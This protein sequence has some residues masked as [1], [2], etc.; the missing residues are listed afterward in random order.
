[1]TDLKVR[2]TTITERS[3]TEATVEIWISDDEDSTKATEEISISV[4]V[5][6]EK[7]PLLA[8]VQGAA[9]E[10]AQTVLKREIQVK[11]LLA[12]S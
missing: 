6:Y 10:C 7:N 11:K 5:K 8:E 3:E 9:L 1:M 4:R 12:N 2:C